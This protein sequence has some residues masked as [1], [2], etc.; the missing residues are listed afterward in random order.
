[1]ANKK[2]SKNLKKSK[3]ATLSISCLTAVTDVIKESVWFLIVFCFFTV[4]SV[5][6]LQVSFVIW[7]LLG[8][9]S[10]CLDLQGR[11]VKKSLI[12]TGLEYFLSLFLLRYAPN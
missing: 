6:F 3:L 1:L 2:K 11:N 10:Q 5:K 4:G 8:R 12:S 7:S 9:N